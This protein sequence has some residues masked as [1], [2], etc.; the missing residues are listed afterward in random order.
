M[1]T[2][3][4]VVV[5]S[6]NSSA[7]VADDDCAADG[8]D[9]PTIRRRSILHL[10]PQGAPTLGATPSERADARTPR[11]V[12]LEG[13]AAHVGDPVGIRAADG[14][15]H[16]GA[17]LMATAIGCLV[18]EVRGRRVAGRTVVAHPTAWSDGT[19]DSLREALSHTGYVE[20]TL[21]SEAAA[22][23]HWLSAARGPLGRNAVVVYDL[24][25][26]SLDISVLGEVA[27]PHGAGF[28][29]LGPPIR[30]EDITG[31]RFDHLIMSSVLDQL[32]LDLD[33]YAPE[34]EQ[35]LTGLRAR[36]ERAKEAL[37]ADLDAAVTVELPGLRRDIRL[38]RADVEDL[39]RAPLRR[40]A[41]LIA[42]ALDGARLTR[43]DVSRVLLVGGGSA[44]PL[45]TEVIAA[46]LGLPVAAAA[47]PDS[48]VT[49]G[50][51]LLARDLSQDRPAGT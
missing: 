17:E 4:G 22:A 33:P 19:V 7:A 13:F 3:I 1:A 10:P 26:A 49:H 2:G 16:D 14:S 44:I 51:A 15:A 5:G 30:S 18:R 41:D 6:R 24:G 27:E 47:R 9:C 21:V 45:A 43:D 38:V 29:L 28:P 11:G 36:C 42:E 37:S 23:M 8:S 39:L 50:A 46:E 48:A 32:G 31:S 40:S 25:A 35:A 12:V 34:T 20:A